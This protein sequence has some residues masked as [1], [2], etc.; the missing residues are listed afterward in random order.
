MEAPDIRAT[1]FSNDFVQQ[2][3]KVA[4]NPSLVDTLPPGI[5]HAFYRAHCRLTRNKTE[6]SEALIEEQ[7]AREKSLKAR[8]PANGTEVK[9]VANTQTDFEERLAA[10]EEIVAELRDNEDEEE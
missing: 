4:N 2:L 5:V 10:L 3:W 6:E 9:I 8:A 7:K 1:E